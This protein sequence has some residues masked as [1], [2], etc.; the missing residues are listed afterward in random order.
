MIK[1]SV[2][3]KTNDSVLQKIFDTAKNRIKEN[4]YKFDNEDIIIDGGGYMG[5]WPES[6]PVLNRLIANHDM[7]VAVNGQ[8][9]WMKYQRADGRIPGM[10]KQCL[11]S[12]TDNQPGISD[13]VAGVAAY[14]G[15]L[16]GIYFQETALD[17]YYLAE[18]D[19]TYLKQLYDCLERYDSYLWSCRDSDGDGCLEVWCEWDL[20]EDK[21]RRYQGTP[22][23]WSPDYPPEGYDILPIESTD[24]MSISFSCCTTNARISAILNNGMSDFWTEKAKNIQK[25]MF[26]YLWDD[27]RKAFYDRDGKNKVIDELQHC[28]IRAL[29]FGSL[30]QEKA[31]SF[32]TTHL[33]N[34]NEFW[35]PMPLPCVAAND[36]MYLPTDQING[37]CGSPL[38]IT[39]LRSILGFDKY[40]YY[41]ETTHLYH[42]L[43]DAIGEDCHFNV[44][45]DTFSREPSGIKTDVA[46]SFAIV[47][48]LSLTAL[49]H[50]VWIKPNEQIY[51]SA[52]DDDNDFE[53]TQN[54]GSLKYKI[55]KNGNIASVFYNDKKMFDFPAGFRIVTNL[56]CKQL[57]AIRIEEG[58]KEYRA[59]NI[60]QMLSTNEVYSFLD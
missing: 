42:C 49:T 36:S 5:L 8:K 23:G 25:K 47:A 30:T 29:Y 44:H 52:L 59:N 58:P 45:Y 24:M 39:Y 43:K 12:T 56:E 27:E 18:L 19:E 31:D 33:R 11:T 40:G 22:Y 48:F 50:G 34:E 35:T 9:I 16:Q 53:Y 55:V 13:E 41:A 15:W 32:V 26:E 28:N 21:A 3:F 37:T 1:T 2:S 4:Y 7:E 17:M 14:Y 57:K 20:G 10:I 54:W 51:F 60:T 6:S 38:M 46:S